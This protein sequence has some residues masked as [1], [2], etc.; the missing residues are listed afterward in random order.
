MF[1]TFSQMRDAVK[2]YLEILLLSKVINWYHPT[3]GVQQKCP[4]E[5]RRA[6]ALRGPGSNP[7]YR[8]FPASSSP[9]LISAG[10]FSSRRFSVSLHAAAQTHKLCTHNRNIKITNQNIFVNT[11]IAIPA[12]ICVLVLGIDGRASRDRTDNLLLEGEM[13]K[14]N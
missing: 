13:S 9:S 2:R 7:A 3:R 8:S 4:T 1:S 10:S 12:A 6:F 5:H 14:A 11:L